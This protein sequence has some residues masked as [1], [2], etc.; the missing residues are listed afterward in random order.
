MRWNRSGSSAAG[1]SK[2]FS[3]SRI[4]ASWTMSSAA[5]S[6]RTA[7]TA[8]FHARFST[9]LRKSESSL[10]VAKKTGLRHQLGR[11]ELSHRPARGLVLL[12]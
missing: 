10:S 3:E 9:L 4:I 11:M 6:S 12:I 1:R 2:Y 7:Y 8:R 5:S